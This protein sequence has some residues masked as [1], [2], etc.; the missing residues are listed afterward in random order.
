ML[1]SAIA[2]ASFILLSIFLVARRR[3]EKGEH[4]MPPRVPINYIQFLKTASAGQ[5]PQSLLKW[6]RQFGF[7]VF[8]VRGIKTMIIVGDA[9]VMHKLLID[10]SVSKP[11]RLYKRAERVHDGG[12]NMFASNGERWF[13]AHKAILPAFSTKHIRRMTEVTVVEKTN[14]FIAQLDANEG[15]SFDVGKEMINLTLKIICDAAFEYDMPAP[16]Q[17]EFLHDLE[18]IMKENR[19]API[20]FRWRFGRFIPAVHRSWDAS[21]RLFALGERILASYRKLEDPTEGTVIECIVNDPKYKDDKERIADLIIL[22]AAGHD[23]TGYSLAWTLLE[24]AKNP[25]EQDALRTELLATPAEERLNSKALSNVIKESMRLNP[26]AALGGV[27]TSSKDIIVNTSNGDSKGSTFLIPK[28]SLMF[29]TS[30]LVLHNPKYFKDPDEFQP[31]R[32]EFPSKEATS[33]Y[34]P[35]L[36]G[37]RACLGQGLANAEMRYVLSRLVADYEFTVEDEGTSTFFVTY[38]P[39]NCMLVAKKL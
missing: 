39:I 30:H 24:L 9:G 32:W 19:N 16:E 35:F 26:V 5:L 36:V 2:I 12:T 28:G 14:N 18:L 10:K 29:L 4:A 23:T 11:Y 38:K 7:D 8:C 21:K 3:R 20:P 27:R 17:A 13:H 37:P 25:A 22:L 31:S 6:S 34:M 1:L 33:A 15:K